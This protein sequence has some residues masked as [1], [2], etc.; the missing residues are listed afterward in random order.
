MEEEEEEEVESGCSPEKEPQEGSG[1]TAAA[2]GKKNP[3]WIFSWPGQLHLFS[4]EGHA[5]TVQAP[6]SPK[7]PSALMATGAMWGGVLQANPPQM[8]RAP[9]QR[10]RTHKDMGERTATY[11]TYWNKESKSRKE[12]EESC[13]SI[14]HKGWCW[15]PGGNFESPSKLLL[16]PWLRRKENICVSSCHHLG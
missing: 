8:P 9:T 10:R 16:Q 1:T 7:R 15:S 13:P 11:P 2:A 14:H 3:S 6:L 12:E 4:Q 5:D